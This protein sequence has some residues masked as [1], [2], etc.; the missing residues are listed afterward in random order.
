MSQQISTILIIIACF[1]IVVISTAELICFRQFRPNKVKQNVS[2]Q[3]ATYLAISNE[4]NSESQTV[5]PEGGSNI[6]PAYISQPLQDDQQNH[7]VS[8]MSTQEKNSAL[9]Y[10]NYGNSRS[11]ELENLDSNDYISPAN[12]TQLSNGTISGY[13]VPIKRASTNPELDGYLQPMKISPHPN[14]SYIKFNSSTGNF[15]I[16]N[17]QEYKIIPEIN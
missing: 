2:E 3:S 16:S 7:R 5:K 17:H 12:I 4:I 11:I 13:E 8:I 14:G 1:V 15:E 6:E 10:E 9:L